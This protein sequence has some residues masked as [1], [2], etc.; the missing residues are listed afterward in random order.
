[1]C[2]HVAVRSERR[3]ASGIELPIRRKPVDVV[4]PPCRGRP[5]SLWRSPSAFPLAAVAEKIRNLFWQ[6]INTS[7]ARNSV[8]S[9]QGCLGH[10]VA[11]DGG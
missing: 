5:S 4:T 7:S 2:C 9:S 8:H 10:T 1:M 11:R 3:S 6:P